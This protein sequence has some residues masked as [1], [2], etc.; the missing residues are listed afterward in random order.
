M[1]VP[2]AR[3][4]ILAAAETGR[5]AATAGFRLTQQS[6]TDPQVGVVVYQAIYDPDNVFRFNQNIRPMW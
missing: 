4:A 5:P 2:A 6:S 1:S 3:E